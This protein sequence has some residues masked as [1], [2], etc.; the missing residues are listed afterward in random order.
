METKLVEVWIGYNRL[1]YVS[2]EQGDHM[3]KVHR[4]WFPQELRGDPI[5]CDVCNAELQY[6]YIWLLVLEDD[7]EA[8]AWGTYC[9]SCKQK[10]RP[11]LKSF[12]IPAKLFDVQ[13]CRYCFKVLDGNGK[14]PDG[15][16]DNFAELE[17]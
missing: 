3:I 14:C 17:G 10:Y 1:V 5:V 8:S 15:C 16:E 6:P 11:K 4:S 2:K 9:E 7:G 12:I 13:V